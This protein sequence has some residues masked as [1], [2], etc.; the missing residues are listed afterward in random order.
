MKLQK[1]IPVVLSTVALASLVG[2]NKTKPGGEGVIQIVAYKAGYGVDWLHAAADEFTKAFPNVSFEFLE[3]SALA[4]DKAKNDIPSPSKNQTD[5]YFVSTTDV[6]D[7]ISRSYNI[8]KTR[9]SVLLEPLDDIFTSKAIDKDGFEEKETIES[10]FLG[11]FKEAVVYEGTTPSKWDNKMFSLPWAQGTT[12]ICYNPALLT[13]YGI[14]VP[15][16]SNE[17]I[18]AIKSI[19]ELGAA[20]DVYPY[21]FAGDNAS[22]YW[23]YLYETWFAQYSGQKGFERFMR[24]E[25]TTGTIKDNGYEVYNDQGILESLKAMFELLDVKY[26]PKGDMSKKHTEAQTDFVTGKSV[27]MVDGDWLLNEMKE[28]YFEQTKEIK[29]LRTPILSS[30]GEEIGITDEQLHT[31]VDMIDEHKTNDDIKAALTSLDD[32]KIAR[33]REA[34]S[35]TC[36]QGVSHNILIP[37][38]SDA[39]DV[40]KLFVR[41]LYSN[42]GCR[43]FRNNAYSNL[44]I[45]Y[46]KD[47]ADTNT[48]WQQSLDALRDYEDA[49]V[50]SESA[51]YNNVRNL[52]QLFLFNYQT[53][54]SPT[55]F[56]TIMLEKTK[57]APAFTAQSIFEREYAHVKSSWSGY[58]A[59]VF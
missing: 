28:D 3:E 7:I 14:D 32:L 39:K 19:Y 54:I 10:R 29:M 57:P 6:D 8:L 59:Y 13:K 27:F 2:C 25:P 51:P 49:K 22:G 37:S 44:P 30:I 5:L 34:R 21:S 18:S 56:K 50:I 36:S 24:C 43:I 20:D 33:V 41:F 38:Y 9:D 48:P 31:L 23:A 40:A 15:R 1:F 45:K 12:G 4:G 55:T 17:F 52:A 16:T 42:D 58:M 53:W 26:A 35:I 47:S 46:T 11:G